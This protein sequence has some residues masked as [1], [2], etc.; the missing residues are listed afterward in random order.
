MRCGMREP[1]ELKVRCYADFVID[2]NKY[3]YVL[4]RPKESDEIG[5][6]ELNKIL[7]KILLNVWGK[8]AYV[9]DFY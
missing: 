6:M 2:I 5:D 3:L 4:T 1:Q 8:Q 9:Q 7:L